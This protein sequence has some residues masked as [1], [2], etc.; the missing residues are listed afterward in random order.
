MG[1]ARRI[2]LR[3]QPLHCTASGNSSSSRSSRLK[4]CPEELSYVLLWS[5]FAMSEAAMLLEPNGTKMSSLY[6]NNNTTVSK[7]I[8]QTIAEYIPGISFTEM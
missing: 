7:A 1:L 8:D 6:L 3:S 5:Y 2:V 4:Y